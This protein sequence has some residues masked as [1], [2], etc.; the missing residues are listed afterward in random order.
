[1]DNNLR[2]Y[3]HWLVSGTVLAIAVLYV[4]LVYLPG[5]RN[6]AELRE[7]LATK[8]APLDTSGAVLASIASTEKELERTEQFVERWRTENPM[9]SGLAPILAELHALAQVAGVSIVRL[10]PQP[11]Q[12]F[13]TIKRGSLTL[14][15]TG[16]YRAVHRFLYQIEQLRHETW[17]DSVSIRIAGGSEGNVIAE[18]VLLMFAD[19]HKIS[20]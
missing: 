12:V 19:N 6:L 15:C 16:S 18:V 2:N 3:R 14:T 1:M 13:D 10:D 8:Q 17:V 5:R 9:P 4:A 20:H 7:Q 11:V